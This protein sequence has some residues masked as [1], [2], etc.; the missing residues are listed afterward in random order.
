MVIVL[1]NITPRPPVNLGKLSRPT[2]DLLAYP[3]EAKSGHAR[4]LSPTHWIVG[5]FGISQLPD[6]QTNLLNSAQNYAFSAGCP[7]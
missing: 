1:K 5:K 2:D 6:K 4:I 7:S 3:G